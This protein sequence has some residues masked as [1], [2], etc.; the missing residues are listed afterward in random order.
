M[1]RGTAKDPKLELYWAHRRRD[2]AP[3]Q[4]ASLGTLAVIGPNFSHFL[5][6]P[7]TE[8]RFNRKR[9]LVC[10]EELCAGGL[11]TI[12]HLSA[13]MPG[14]WSFWREFLAERPSVTTVAI[15]FQTGNKGKTQGYKALENLALVQR[16]IGRALHPVI[17]G[18]GQFVDYVAGRFD[19]FTL[20]DGYPFMKAVMRQRFVAKKGK[21]FVE[22]SYSLERQ[23]IDDLVSQNIDSYSEWVESKLASR[24]VLASD[25]VSSPEVRASSHEESSSI[26]PVRPR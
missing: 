16:D 26:S 1:L 21:R 19:R 11:S 15:E 3:Q 20:M 6:V 13:V 8:N 24:R 12:P 17:I 25:F 10:L 18:G 4:L 14:D 22:P 2:G 23:P 9:Q 7:R 5:G